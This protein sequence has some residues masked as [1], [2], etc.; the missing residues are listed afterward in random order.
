MKAWNLALSFLLLPLSLQ[1]QTV[2][3]GA[4]DDAAPWSYADGT[5]YVND[6]VRTAFQAV[7]WQVNYRVLPYARC[8][9][10]TERGELDACFSTSKTPETLVHLQF[11][12]TPVFEARNVLFANADSGLKGCN[13]ASWGRKISIGYVSGYEYSQSVVD[14]QKSGQAASIT[15]NSEILLVRMLT[16]RRFDAA[17]VTVDPAKRIELVAQLAHVAPKFREVCDFG[18]EPAYL[19]FSK[20]RPSAGAALQ[21]F[22]RGMAIITKD[23]TV[24]RLQKYWGQRALAIEA[25]K[26]H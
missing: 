18:G 26:K 5:G 7:Q 1:A 8:K 3:I 15:V 12:D 10:L 20:K 11:P 21:A 22:N 24:K 2:T 4:E 9:L 25:A 14:L 16:A 17:L 6:L 23:G 19:A 13:A